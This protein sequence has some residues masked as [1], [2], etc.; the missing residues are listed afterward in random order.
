VLV[1]LLEQEQVA[2]GAPQLL[3]FVGVGCDLMLKLDFWAD[4]ANI[5]FFFFLLTQNT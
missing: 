5:F 4:R 3:V 1:N 2:Q